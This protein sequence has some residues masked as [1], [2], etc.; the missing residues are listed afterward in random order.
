MQVTIKAKRPNEAGRTVDLDEASAQWLLANGYAEPDDV[1]LDEEENTD[2][3]PREAELNRLT[4]AQ[5]RE[6]A[7]Q[8]ELPS[9]G[10]KA[11]L[12]ARLAEHEAAA[13]DADDDHTG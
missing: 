3:D 5:L 6:R 9:T 2:G 10:T 12:V 13:E 11:E 8:H 4:V 7:G 1:V